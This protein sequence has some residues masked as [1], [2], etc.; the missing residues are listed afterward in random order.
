MKIIIKNI[1]EYILFLCC[2]SAEVDVSDLYSF[3]IYS[4]DYKRKHLTELTARKIIRKFRYTP[5]AKQARNKN[6][7]PFGCKS[8]IRL[9]KSRGEG[10]AINISSE[11]LLHYN[12]V[13]PEMG[14]TRAGTSSGGRFSGTASHI[15]RQRRLFKIIQ[16]FHYNGMIVDMLS[17]ELATNI[18]EDFTASSNIFEGF[19]K[20]KTI[21]DNE[22]SLLPPEEIIS[23]LGKKDKCFLTIKAL[24]KLNI[25]TDENG[26]NIMFR[27]FGLLIKGNVVYSIYMVG[28][29][30]ETWNAN[31][32][33]LSEMQVRRIT[34]SVLDVNVEGRGAAIFYTPNISV[35]ED[36]FIRK[37]GT[38]NRIR[39][40][41]VYSKAYILP[42]N[43][44]TPTL[45][46]L[47]LID[48]W[49]T[50]TIQVL[51][52]S[53]GGSITPEK[54]YDGLL[55]GREVYNLLA[56]DI[57]K[58][59]RARVRA[60]SRPMI[61]LIQSWQEGL[62]KEYFGENKNVIIWSYSERELRDLHK[63]IKKK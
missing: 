59:Q 1:E 37:N 41:L 7:N 9:T 54:E 26:K 51:L 14:R 18:Q 32:E 5:T 29:A 30:N 28:G 12:L 48:N 60:G 62:V 6:Y 13:A 61:L 16:H 58:M 49:E 53:N 45:E 3:G 63:M 31:N 47:L 34:G 55:K 15:E 24:S 23:R 44:A 27:S 46:D 56:N 20:D 36:I 40:E 2:L 21:F 25:Q 11:L 39:P 35:C 17:F 4:T 8:Q 57:V 43:E 22:G 42:I 50:K 19:I 52:E 38:K 33:E 10:A